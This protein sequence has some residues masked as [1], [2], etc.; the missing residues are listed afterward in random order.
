MMNRKP[1]PAQNARLEAVLVDEIGEQGVEY[2]A[3]L[4]KNK[5]AVWQ[6]LQETP[7]TWTLWNCETDRAIAVVWLKRDSGVVVREFKNAVFGDEDAQ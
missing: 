6:E 4:V 3:Q 5:K 2:V 1:T 7:G